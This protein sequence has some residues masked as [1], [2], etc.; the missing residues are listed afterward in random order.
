MKN[1]LILIAI[2]CVCLLGA[3]TKAVQPTPE[4]GS[5]PAN[6]TKTN[7]KG[8]NHLIPGVDQYRLLVKFKADEIQEVSRNKPV[9]LNKEKAVTTMSLDH[10]NK[11]VNSFTY[12]AVFPAEPGNN[13]NVVV[14]QEK[15]GSTVANGFNSSSLRG[16]VYVKEATAL[17][18]QAVLDLANEFE[19]L[20]VVEYAVLEPVIPPPPPTPDFTGWQYYKK[21]VDLSGTDVR[22]IDAE[23][24]WS[25]GVTGSGIRIADIEWGYN[26]NHE[27]LVNTSAIEVLS[28]PDDQYKDHGTSVIG[29]LM[30]QNNSFGVTGMVYGA[31]SCYVISERVKGRAGGI[32]AG[33]KRLRRGDVF[34]YE[35]QTSGPSG[36]YVPADY[37]QAVWDITKE[38]ANSGIIIVAAAGNG[39]QN[40]DDNAYK[41]YRDRGD[42]GAIIVGAGTK[43]KRDKASFSTYGSSVH[44]QGW[45]DWSVASTGY[46][47][48]YNGGPN[49]Q[50]TKDFSGTSSAT[51]IVA[52]AVIAIQSWYK[53]RTGQ[54]LTPKEMRELLIKTGTPQGAGGHIG[55][56]PNI[57][58]AIASLA[59]SKSI[60]I[61]AGG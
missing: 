53:S 37:N 42:N 20:A 46:T 30:A 22:G 50:Y 12:E 35:M 51:P 61:I 8:Q 52:S 57:K 58:A 59:A 28:P 23:Y 43:S 39:N 49:A 41:A 10:T 45:G 31:D 14:N 21:D 34:L 18:P 47:S 2:V 11:D 5:N 24:A 48:L 1:F 7:L 32:A 4:P 27:D 54:V 15:T 56:L 26:K 17:S 36:Q 6:Q 16:L 55:P 13:N 33:I 44:V 29:I 3:C 60:S 25:I 40:L 9:F 38:A 19:K